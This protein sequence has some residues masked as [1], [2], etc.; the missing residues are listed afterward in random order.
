MGGRHDGW[1]ARS[2]A[3]LRDSPVCS[4]AETIIAGTASCRI[5]VDDVDGLHAELTGAGVL[6]P[7]DE[8]RPRGHR[9]RGRAS[10]PR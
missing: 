10:S 4:G 1:R 6:H 2:L 8:G 3:E 5:Q 7:V 9:P